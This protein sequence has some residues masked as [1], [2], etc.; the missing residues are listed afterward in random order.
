MEMKV[1][2][3]G[4]EDTEVE[5]AWVKDKV[6]TIAQYYDTNF[7]IK[8]YT[9]EACSVEVELCDKQK[10]VYDFSY[11]HDWDAGI[12]IYWK[13][14]K[15]IADNYEGDSDKKKDAF[16]W[17]F[18]FYLAREMYKFLLIHYEKA[19]EMKSYDGDVYDLDS[20][21]Y[22]LLDSIS[23]YFALCYFEAEAGKA[24]KDYITHYRFLWGC[25]NVCGLDSMLINGKLVYDFSEQKY[26]GK[27]RVGKK[28][29]L[30]CELYNE[31]EQ[32]QYRDGLRMI[33][34]LKGEYTNCREISKAEYERF[35]QMYAPDKLTRRTTASE[36]EEIS[37]LERNA[38]LFLWEKC[39]IYKIDSSL[40]RHYIDDGLLCL[41]MAIHRFM[42]TGSK[43]D[44]FDVYC[45]YSGRFLRGD[46][47][48]ELINFISSYE[49]NASRLVQSHRDHYSH[50]A[51]VFVLG[52][53]IYYTSDILQK[54]FEKKYNAEKK[55]LEQL[56]LK[57]ENINE[58]FLRLWGL[59]ALFHDIGYQYEI[60]FCQITENNRYSANGYDKV[61]YFHYRNMDEFSN[62]DVFFKG[63]EG[64]AW[65]RNNLIYNDDNCYNHYKK[66]LID[67]NEDYQ[68]ESIED[69]LAFHID[70]ALGR[71]FPQDVMKGNIE[72]NVVDDGELKDKTWT[73]VEYIAT[74]LK[75]KP[76]P[77]ELK[78]GNSIK[79]FMDHAYYSAIVVFKQLIS[80]YGL[81]EF[82]ND[83]ESDKY[84]EKD[85]DNSRFL[86]LNEWMDAITAI[87][88]HNKF[89]EFNLKTV[90][91]KS[92]ESKNEGVKQSLCIS[93]HPLA[94]LLILCDELQCW[95]RTSFG[96]SSISQLHAI[97][98]NLTFNAN[99]VHAEY[100][101]DQ[102]GCETAI[103]FDDNGRIKS[104]K[105]GTLQ[106]FF[107]NK[108]KEYVT[109]NHVKMNDCSTWTISSHDFAEGEDCKFVLDIHGIVDVAGDD[110][111]SLTVAAKFGEGTKYRNEYLSEISMGKLYD[112]A[113]K[114]YEKQNSEKEFEYGDIADKILFIE[115]VKG[116][117]ENLQKVNC[118]YSN[119]LKA[120]DRKY[121]FDIDERDK[122]CGLIKE[123]MDICCNMHAK[124]LLDINTIRKMFDDFMDI[125]KDEPGIEIY[126]L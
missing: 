9:E 27:T 4:Q 65:E 80:M 43:N 34:E 119:Q 107:K 74:L 11:Y 110:N 48:Q 117:G 68:P 56:Y 96:K 97:D 78:D 77:K 22:K 91:G 111:L 124:E 16:L 60:P 12:S 33:D 114:L 115:F 112:L 70:R 26:S 18:E 90:E 19:G 10:G 118:F 49:N 75:A 55:L 1:F 89:F 84:T 120:F 8:E 23:C 105:A 14:L 39:K 5:A 86:T 3:R 64:K 30:Y 6:K 28:L 69:V 126:S 88:M 54:N 52:L 76:Y 109:P 102:K 35:V 82:T 32:G 21:E 101:F 20:E 31:Y 7:K 57:K 95:D 17:F 83:L 106:K 37:E 100:I 41:Y 113:G 15:K 63:C 2:V 72:K 125:M 99:S 59:T 81:D 79:A 71:S 38:L 53:A 46:K 98:C 29:D 13:M 45:S 50:S 44:A 25:E 67:N 40:N 73:G 47:M 93:E 66:L 42:E 36:S 123:S 85:V 62:L 121:E 24:K 108:A 58:K 104:V 51:Y 103:G 122:I 116:M 92:A 61:I 94:Y 87:A